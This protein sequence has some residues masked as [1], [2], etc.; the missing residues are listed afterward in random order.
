M[1][2]SVVLAVMAAS[3]ALTARAADRLEKSV[4]HV[5]N[6]SQ[7]ANWDAPW[8]MR[9]VQSATGTGFSIGG[10]RI[11]TNAH[12]VADARVV[13][14]HRF[15][16]A[17]PYV[18]AE[19]M[20]RLLGAET[21]LT[22]SCVRAR[23]VV[24]VQF[25]YTG[26]YVAGTTDAAG[27]VSYDLRPVNLDPGCDDG[28]NSVRGDS[29]DAEEWHDSGGYTCKDYEA[30]HWCNGGGHCGGDQ[31]TCEDF[32]VDGVSAKMACCTCGGGQRWWTRVSL[33]IVNS[34]LPAALAPRVAIVRSDGYALVNETLQA[35]M[36]GDAD[37]SAQYARDCSRLL[38]HLDQMK[39]PVVAA[40]NGIALG[41]GFELA[42]RCHSIVALKRAWIQMPEVTLG[43]THGIGAMA[44]PYRR[45]PHATA[46]F[47]AMLRQA[48]RLKATRA[49]E[50][51]IVS[52]LADDYSSLIALAAAR[53]GELANK[54]APIGDA[55]VAVS[56]EPVEARS[57][58]GQVLSR[59]C[60]DIME[61]AIREAAAAP[62][63]AAALEAGYQAFGRSA[64]TGAAREGI[65]SF[66]EKRPADFSKTK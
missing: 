55:P 64:C 63:F 31:W 48:E 2:T 52:G 39:K 35:Y 29:A 28:A 53:V 56:I 12:V 57:S 49:H 46:T 60:I 40:L 5:T 25:Y 41:G 14:L 54:I 15:Q 27:V 44:V 36:L 20:R 1:R 33:Q 11:M 7:R 51:G 6:Y 21:E 17:T 66:K 50:L 24:N 65:T 61:Q 19:R 59:E 22:T 38:V 4:V 30:F 13:Q 42:S 8:E 37:A 3:A 47:N 62:S 58:N 43:I 32:A 34:A 26:S 18:A 10:G 16:D 9:G 23:G 45:W